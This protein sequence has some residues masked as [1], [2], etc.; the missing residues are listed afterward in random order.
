MQ[1]FQ[2]RQKK[3]LFLIQILH[4]FNLLQQFMEEFLYRRKMS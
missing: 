1:L 2:F 3:K 4:K